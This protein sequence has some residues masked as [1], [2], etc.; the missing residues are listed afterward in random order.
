MNLT[1]V[2][3]DAGSIPGLDKWIED[4]VLLQLWYGLAAAAPIQPL[5]WDPPCASGVALKRQKQKYGTSHHGSTEMN[6]TSILE[7]AGSIPGLSQ[8]LKDLTLP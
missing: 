6:L 7:D 1:G 3:E 8:L 2:H 4:P 5:A